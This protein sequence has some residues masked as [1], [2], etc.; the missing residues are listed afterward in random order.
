MPKPSGFL[1]DFPCVGGAYRGDVVGIVEAR[2][3]KREVAVVFHPFD[4]EACRRQ[5]DL[6]HDVGREDAL[7][8]EVVDGH[9]RRRLFPRHEVQ[10]SRYQGALPVIAVNDVGA[11]GE[12]RGVAAEDGADPGKQGEALGVVRPVDAGRDSGRGRRRAGRAPG[13]R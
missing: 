8:G 6:G 13:S 1:L 10:E 3:E 2:L 12:G 11:E 7:E 9:H 5:A 4:A